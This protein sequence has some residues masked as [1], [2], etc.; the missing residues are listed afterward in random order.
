MKHIVR[1]TLSLL[2]VWFPHLGQSAQTLTI[3]QVVDGGGWQSTIVLTNS[4][5]NPASAT[6]IFHSDKAS[7]GVTQAWT[8]PF[9]ETSSTAGLS[10]KGGSTMFLHTAGTAA[11]LTQG[12]AELN[13]DAGV[14]AYVVFT[15]RITGLRDQDGTAPAVAVTNRVLVP[16]DDA[17]GFATAIAVVN[18]TGAAQNISVGFRATTGGVATASLPAVPPMGHMAFVLAQQFPAIAGHSGL[19]EFYDATGNFSMISLRFNPTQ[20]FTEAP[21]YLQTGPAIIVATPNPPPPTPDP[22]PY[23]IGTQPPQR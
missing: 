5:L 9:L 21:V 14:I 8:P 4:T 22:Y 23:S 15:N 17:S 16:Y 1:V 7:G 11:A 13:A 3:P 19:A 10:L 18:P 20:S 2:S 6:L 12:W